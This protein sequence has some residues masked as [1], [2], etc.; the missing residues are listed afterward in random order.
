RRGAT[1]ERILIPAATILNGVQQQDQ[2]P[3][4]VGRR[5]RTIPSQVRP[6]AVL[7]LQTLRLVRIRASR[8]IAGRPTAAQ[9]VGSPRR[10]LTAV[11]G[12]LMPAPQAVSAAMRFSGASSARAASSMWRRTETTA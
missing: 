4:L 11:R 2:T 6:V 10:T 12:L 9:T 5:V 1:T 7:A 8:A 3:A